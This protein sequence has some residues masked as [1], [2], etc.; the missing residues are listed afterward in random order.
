MTPEAMHMMMWVM[1]DRALPRSYATMEGFGIH[2]FR[3][4]NEAGK[5]RFVKFHW[6][7]VGN[8]VH[9]LIWDEAQKV[10]GKDADFNRRDLFDSIEA[11]I[12]PEWELG[13]QI[14][15]KQ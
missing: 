14:V 9:S 13:I 5:S 1:S 10:S 8:A 4:V 11:G 3:L 12:F 7:P 15:E 2:T 6:K